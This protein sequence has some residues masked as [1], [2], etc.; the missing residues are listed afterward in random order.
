MGNQLP[1]LPSFKGSGQRSAERN[2]LAV[3]MADDVVEI[4][5][6]AVSAVD[7]AGVPDDLREP[8]FSAVL[9]YRGLGKLAGPTSPQPPIDEGIAAPPPTPDLTVGVGR[10][11]QKLKLPAEQVG[12]VFEVDE[13][14]VHL[15]VSSS[16]LDQK[17]KVAQ[18]ELTQLFVAGRQAGGVDEGLTP[19]DAVREVLS[20]FGKLD[21]N[22][23]SNIASLKGTLMRF[24]GSATKREFKMNQ[25]GYEAVA[26]IVKRLTE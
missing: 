7:E 25:P 22:F 5:K 12:S 4:L 19:V 24:S 13:D 15:L 18:Q 6:S 8:A 2:K 14:T 3:Q 10:I 16:S 23:S 11:A 20:D 1:D 9:A 26:E 17:V 21:R